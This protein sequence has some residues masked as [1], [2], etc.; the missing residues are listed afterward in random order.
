MTITQKM[1]S[2]FMILMACCFVTAC[3]SNQQAWTAKQDLPKAQ[4]QLVEKH[5]YVAFDKSS[6]LS[7]EKEELLRSLQDILTTFYA[8]L[9]HG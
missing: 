9:R 8:F 5:Y 7:G 4:A 6:L 1:K 3:S 2:S